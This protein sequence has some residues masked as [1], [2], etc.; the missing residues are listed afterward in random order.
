MH[1]SDDLT[2]LGAALLYASFGAV[3]FTGVAVGCFATMVGGINWA[4]RRM[5]T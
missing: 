1:N 4:L 2:H 3:V 5:V